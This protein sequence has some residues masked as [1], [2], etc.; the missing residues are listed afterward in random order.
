LRVL[1]TSGYP[2]GAIVEYGV[3]VTETLISKPF[4]PIGLA[5]KIRAVLDSTH[6]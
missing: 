4:S 3:R 2:D 6:S 5:R 1:Y